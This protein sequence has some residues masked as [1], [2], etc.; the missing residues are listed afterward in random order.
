ML[1]VLLRIFV[2]DTKITFGYTFVAPLTFL[3]KLMNHYISNVEWLHTFPTGKTC[4]EKYLEKKNIGK[5]YWKYI[6]KK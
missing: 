6:E 3:L 1:V 4:W 2:V 5:I